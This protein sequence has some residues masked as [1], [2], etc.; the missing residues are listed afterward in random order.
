MISNRIE[1]L[2][3]QIVETMQ[4]CRKFKI[5]VEWC[6]RVHIDKSIKSKVIQMI[7]KE[8]KKSR[9][10]IINMDKAQLEQYFDRFRDN[11]LEK[12]H[13]EISDLKSER[14][15]Y[16]L[17]I[18]KETQNLREIL[19]IKYPLKLKLETKTFFDTKISKFDNSTFKSARKVMCLTPEKRSRKD[20]GRIKP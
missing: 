19:D 20:S 15:Y 4:K 1:Y 3:D 10:S 13:I 12:L 9:R 18:K 8:H 17:F 2:D 16:I 7:H 5:L 11:G 6:R 14:D